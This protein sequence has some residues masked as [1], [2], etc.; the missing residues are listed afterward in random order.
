MRSQRRLRGAQ[1]LGFVRLL[2][3][4]GATAQLDRT[5]LKIPEESRDASMSRE[6]HGLLHGHTLPAGFGHESRSERMRP[7]I[8]LQT[9]EL[10]P[11]LHDMSDGLTG[12]RLNRLGLADSPENGAGLQ[13]GGAYPRSERLGR[14]SHKGVYRHQPCVRC[15]LDRS[16]S[17]SAGRDRSPRRPSRDSPLWHWPLLSAAD[18]RWRRR[19]GGGRDHEGR[20]SLLAAA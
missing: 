2:K 20:S 11:P 5:L 9:G 10:R 17:V 16:W 14:R 12:E 1:V 8:P 13:P 19:T 7:E 3:Q 4:P 15:R 6:L 18:Y